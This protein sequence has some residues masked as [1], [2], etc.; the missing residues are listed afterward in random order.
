MFIL[1]GH[2]KKTVLKLCKISRSSFYKRARPLTPDGRKENAGRPP[3]GYS[4]D[5]FG[6]KVRDEEILDLLCEYRSQAYFENAGGHRKM[7]HYLRRDQNLIVNHKKLY[8]L[9]KEN[10]L[11]LPRKKKKKKTWKKLCENRKIT[12]PFQLWQFDIKYGFIPGENR[13]FYIMA[14]IDVFHREV[15]NFH[16]GLRCRAKDILLT[17]EEALLKHSVEV[18]QLAIRSDNGPQMTSYQFRDRILELGVKHEFTP[19]STPQKNAFIES[20]FSILETDFLQTHVFKNFSQA[21]T[22]T[23]KFIHFY[24]ERRIHGSIHNQSPKDFLRNWTNE[25]KNEKQML[26]A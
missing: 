4:L 7:V 14:F 25:T 8:R 21:Y 5:V 22:E 19:P 23:I 10:D 17:F 20:F 11:L 24:N 9:C 3:R 15:M 6:N 26:A 18:S 13:F 12:A 2:P 1:E 16:I